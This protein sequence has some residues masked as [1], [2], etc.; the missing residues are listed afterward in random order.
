MLT[1]T[2]A[3]IFDAAEAKKSSFWKNYFSSHNL[4]Y[5][6]SDKTIKSLIGLIN[7]G[8]TIEN[9]EVAV[10][11]APQSCETPYIHEIWKEKVVFTDGRVP[12]LKESWQR[13][14][15]QKIKSL[16]K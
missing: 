3:K 5:G 10:G 4:S 9:F 7:T 2:D 11:K 16:V 1:V 6:L 15:V 13:L 12:S 14:F 8:E